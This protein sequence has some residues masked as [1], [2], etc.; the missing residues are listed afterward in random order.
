MARQVQRHPVRGSVIHV[1]FVIVRRDEVVTTE[2]PIQ[3]VGEAAEVHKN[4]GLIEQA[5]FAL[6]IAAKPADI[7]P[8][9][10]VD[11]SE[12]VIGDSVRVGDL[13]LPSG[14]TTEVDPESPVVVA[15]AARVELPEPEEAVE[16]EEGV[17][18]EAAEGEAA[19]EGGEAPA[20]EGESSAEG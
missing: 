7:P 8:G 5:L 15:Q 20:A 6:P 19:A 9:I 14:V 17:E 4:D 3:L 11:V 13:K 18:G 1:D 16:G 12:M 2:V 10:E